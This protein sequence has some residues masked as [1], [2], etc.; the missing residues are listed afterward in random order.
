MEREQP[1]R[2]EKPRREISLGERTVIEG[3]NS[4]RGK[5]RPWRERTPMGR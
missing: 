5:E 3:E 2:R 4:Y 1:W